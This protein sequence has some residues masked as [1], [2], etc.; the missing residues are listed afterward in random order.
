[1]S[2]LKNIQDYRNIAILQTAFLGDVALVLHLA[3]VVNNI[4][5][6][7]KITLVTTPAA[8]VIGNCSMAIDKVIIYDKRKEHKG[9]KGIRLI[10]DELRNLGTDLI[11]TP[12]RSLRSTITSF[13]TGAVSIG[14]DKNAMSFLYKK[15]VRYR[16]DLHEI[17]RNLKLL[18][19]FGVNP[20]DFLDTK[21]EIKSLDEEHSA[22][23]EILEKNSIGS[24][25]KMIALA[26]GSVWATKK[27]TSE[28]FSRLTNL[29]D[30]NN[31][32]VV[33]IGGPSDNDV[34]QEIEH[35]SKA[36]NL[37]GK[38]T[39]SQTLALL[40]K[41]KLLVTNDSAPTH[42]AGL[43]QCPIIAIFGPTVPEFGFAPRCKFDLVIQDEDL[44][45]RPCAI[46]GSRTCPLKTLDCMKNI[47]AE[48]V[49]DKAMAIL[50]REEDE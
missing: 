23:V 24:D 14:F 3:Q 46:H 16:K 41:C 22:V 31:F 29:L 37:C 1:M 7:A 47:K 12:H 32:K 36:I 10:S 44:E 21:P 17:E 20:N 5:P 9:Y 35:Q 11:F 34:C 45:C 19:P 28:G 18:T 4:N 42:F 38:T 8:A 48:K 6:D 49:F 15:K 50:T 27:W 13:F 2:K 43:M 30:E 25:D 26:P 40:S 39:I 33:L